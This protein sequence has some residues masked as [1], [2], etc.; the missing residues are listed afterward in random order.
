MNILVH[1]QLL[2]LHNAYQFKV[3]LHLLPFGS[4][5]KGGVLRFPI[6]VAMLAVGICTNR[7]TTHDFPMP[8][9]IKFCSIRRRLAE[10]PM[11][12]YA[13]HFDPRLGGQGGPMGSKMLPI[14]MSS[15]HCHATYIYTIGL[16]CTVW[17]QYTTRQ[18]DGAMGIGC[19]C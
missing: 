10:I 4:N 19:I 9:N 3:L 16:A 6:L 14:E 11:S 12:N 8:L 1:L 13:P 5:L 2:R 15:S 17:P 7:K 18:T